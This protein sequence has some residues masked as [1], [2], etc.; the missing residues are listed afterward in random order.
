MNHQRPTCVSGVSERE[1]KR[2]ARSEITIEQ[3]EL[4]DLFYRLECAVGNNHFPEIPRTS[5]KT[6]LRSS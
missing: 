6:C 1:L 2:D 4:I 3:E 5:T